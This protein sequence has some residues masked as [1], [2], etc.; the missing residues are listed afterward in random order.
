[1]AT[2]IRPLAMRY[3]LAMSPARLSE[4]VGLLRRE[5]RTRG[6]RWITRKSNSA[7]DAER[8]QRAALHTGVS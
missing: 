3:G 5:R 1:M 4:L 8:K 7:R 2:A 6:W